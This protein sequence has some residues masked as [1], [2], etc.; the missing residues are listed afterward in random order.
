[1][2]APTESR[3]LRRL[4]I[5]AI[6]ALLAGLVFV[7][8]GPKPDINID[9]IAYF[10]QADE[11]RASYPQHDYWRAVTTTRSYGVMMAY[12]YRLTGDHILTLRIMLAMMTVAYLL[13]AEY[14]LRRFTI[15]GWLAVLFSLASAVHVSFGA[16]FWGVTDFAASLNRT[17]AVPPMLLLLGWYFA[18][19]RRRRRLLVYPGLIYLS[20]IHLGT[21]YLLGVLIAMDGLRLAY[22]LWARR[23]EF[24][25]EAGAY[26]GAFVLVAAAYL[27]IQR[28]NL[29]NP[30]LTTLVPR[31]EYSSASGSGYLTSKEA[32]AME[33]AAQPWR[34]FPPPLATVLGMAASLAFIVPL[35]VA[36]GL[37]AVRRSGWRDTDKPMLLMASCVLIC[38]YSLQCLLWISR[39][40]IPVYPINFEEVRT[41]CFIYLPLL[42][43]IMRGFEWFWYGSSVTG[44]RLV[45]V[46]C[47]LLLVSQPIFLIRLLPR[48]ARERILATAEGAGILEHGES[49]RDIYARQVLGLEGEDER[50][51]YSILPVLGWLRAHTDSSSRVLTN[52]NEL[53]L[54]DAR[55][56]GTSNGFLNT[57]L[58]APV[59]LAWYRGLVELNA[60]LAAHDIGRVRQLAQESGADFAVV[61]WCEPGAAFCS[62][63]YSVIASK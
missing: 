53:Y 16:V 41:I 50:F 1:M 44:H 63:T 59:R 40:W 23:Q 20:L 39:H 57:D 29:G 60:A 18:N 35:A 19:Y 33:I 48:G 37:I 56:I 22:A 45:A 4:Q 42:Y 31:I 2:N 61:P 10:K 34:N 43:F 15:H 3:F 6:Y 36:G 13:C 24:L 28:F 47:A 7:A 17:L 21:Y 55:M 49:P 32:W 5:I 52:R 54:L 26:L 14:F 11:I 25:A 62:R 8:H 12:F 38:A 9:H 51:Y 27:S 58:R 46:C 30:V